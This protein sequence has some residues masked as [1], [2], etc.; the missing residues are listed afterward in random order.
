MPDSFLIATPSPKNYCPCQE[1]ASRPSDG[2]R[3]VWLISLEPRGA[4]FFLFFMTR[5]QDKVAVI[6][7]GNSG[8]GFATAQEFIAQGARVV[9]TGR[10][11]PA[12]QEAVAKLGD[13]A[14]GV[15]SD[16]GSMADVHKL[17]DQVRAHH[18]RIDVLF[19]N[20]DVA[21]FAPIAQVD[22][23]FFDQQF[24]INVKGAY[25]TIQQLLPLLNDNG[26]IILTASTAAHQRAA[27]MSVY[28]ATKAALTTFARTLST[29]LLDRKIRV[30][31][32]SP[33]PVATPILSKTGMSVEAQQ[34]AA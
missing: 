21:F 16:I 11:A 8:I 31:V 33:G 26:A 6:T 1:Q 13:Q 30:N 14:V 4:H 22:E 2:A 17:A 12:V 24:N 29:E 19:V 15:V 20:A 3:L 28:A 7:G 25:F 34:Q 9:I 5:L 32:I 10:N 23:A 18:P 27:G